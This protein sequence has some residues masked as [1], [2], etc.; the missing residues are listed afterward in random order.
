MIVELPDLLPRDTVQT[1]VADLASAPFEDG[2]A[3]ARG[4]TKDLKN[5]LQLTYDHPV[6][7]RWSAH[8]L[9]TLSEHRTVKDAALPKT[10][11]PMR[12]CKYSVGMEYGEHIDAPVMRLDPTAPVRTD[13]A[14]TVWLTD[15]QSYDGGEL[16]VRGP[17]GERALKGD[18]GSAVIYPASTQHRVAPVT[19]GERIVAISWVQSMI[20]LNEQRAI[21]FDLA[22]AIGGASAHP[23]LASDVK[24]LRRAK[25]E[26]VR[27]WAEC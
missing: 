13:L 10:F 26:L 6:A 3:T 1:I 12:F 11:L 21:L 15:K 8:L 2:K 25:N 22:L 24:A 14:L 18:A 19:R 9:K 23:D 17:L 20:R 7:K 4:K 5:N 27:M 16:I